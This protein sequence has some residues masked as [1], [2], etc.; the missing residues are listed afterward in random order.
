MLFAVFYLTHVVHFGLGSAHCLQGEVADAI[1]DVLLSVGVGPVIKWVDDFLI[2]RIPCPEGPFY[3]NG[4]YYAYDRSFLKALIAPLGVPWH[5]DKGTE[6]N[7]EFVYMGFQWSI[8]HRS[9]QLTDEKRVKY[10][11]KLDAFLADSSTFTK[12]EYQSLQGTLS[13]ISFVFPIGRTYL[14]N[15]LV[16]ISSFDD[17]SNPIHT[18]AR[19]KYLPRYVREDLL[20]WKHLLA[21]PSPPRSIAPRPSYT[22]IDI[23]V[24]ASSSTGIGIIIGGFWDA[25]LTKDGALK[26]GSGRDIQWLEA[27]AV[28]LALIILAAQ[29]HS[30]RHFLIRSDN[31]AVIGAHTHSWSRHQYVNKSIRRCITL[32]DSHDL[33]YDLLYIPTAINPADRF[34]RKRFSTSLPRLQTTYTLPDELR[35]FFTHYDT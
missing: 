29:G 14:R 12:K 24:D 5:P 2:F 23:F 8:P 15:F 35:G 19:K 13:H 22:K 10:A 27:V 18:H 20:W 30:H 31:Q 9:V 6:F 32:S 21:N 7:D 11:A 17:P 4:F 25:W 34:S 26:E 1:V 33:S 16:F 3:S 28:E